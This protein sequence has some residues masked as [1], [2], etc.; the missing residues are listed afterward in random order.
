M[1]TEKQ[2]EELQEL[3]NKI[4]NVK[5]VAKIS[6]ISYNTL[7][8]FLIFKNKNRLR[9]NRKRDT[10]KYRRDIKQKLVDYKGGKCQICGYCKCIDA[11]DFHHI[12]PEEKDF[13]ISGGTKSFEHVKSELDKCILVCSNCHR[14]IHAG[15]IKLDKDGHLINNEDAN[16]E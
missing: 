4:G 14:E 3:Y 1:V 2:K 11:L 13:S 10:R 16:C 5:K 15:L 6:H 8:G 9:T 12:N 7:K